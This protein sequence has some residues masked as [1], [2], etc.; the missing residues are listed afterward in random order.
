MST[1]TKVWIEDGEC[2]SCEACVAE[3]PEVFEMTDDECIIKPEAK[4]ADFLADKSEA[5]V[6]A[7]EACPVDAV[8]HE[9]A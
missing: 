5:I 6:E 9:S 1:I 4:K 8:K 3:C 7:A 2:I